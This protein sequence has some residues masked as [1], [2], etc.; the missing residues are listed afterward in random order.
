MT[1]QIAAHHAT[2]QRHFLESICFITRQIHTSIELKWEKCLRVKMLETRREKIGYLSL[3]NIGREILLWT[4]GQFQ[5]DFYLLYL[6]FFNSL[7]RILI[8][9]FSSFF[10]FRNMARNN[11]LATDK[12]LNKER[13]NIWKYHIFCASLYCFLRIDRIYFNVN[14]C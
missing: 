11:E 3:W 7:S 13:I 5:T 2:E 10:F 12:R 6:F 1:A 14:F 8:A 4:T 9:L